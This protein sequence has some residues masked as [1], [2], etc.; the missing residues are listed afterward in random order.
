MQFH[1]SFQGP[2]S[3]AGTAV[4]F[5]QDGCSVNSISFTTDLCSRAAEFA[6]LESDQSRRIQARQTNK[7]K[8]YM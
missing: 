2:S 7:Q 3:H 6:R 8:S 4:T 1:L 5:Q